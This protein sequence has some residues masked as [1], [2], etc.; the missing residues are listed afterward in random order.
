M[1]NA[2]YRTVMTDR[3][4]NPHLHSPQELGFRR[5]ALA[6]ARVVWSAALIFSAACSAAPGGTPGASDF[7]TDGGGGLGGGGDAAPNTGSGAGDVPTPDARSGEGGRAPD[8]GAGGQPPDPGPATPEKPAPGHW[9]QLPPGSYTEGAP[10][11]ESCNGTQNQ[12]LHAVTLSHP[13]ELSATE[14]TFAEYA[15]VFGAEHPAYAGCSSCPVSLVSFHGAAAVCNGYSKYAGL[16]PCYSCQTTAVGTECVEALSP[17]A[18]HGYRLPTE[19]EWEYANRAGT[20]TPIFNGDIVNC[21]GFDVGLDQIAWYLFNASGGAH[22]VAGKQGNA[23]GF[24]DMSGNVWEWTHDGYVSDRSTLPTLNPIGVSSE[25]LRV[26][27]GGSYNCTPEEVRA[28]H[29]SG[30][31]ASIAASNVGLRC[32]RTLD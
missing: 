1:A 19:A 30:L 21:S 4:L 22:P 28:A 24:Y 18:C 11:T 29:R 3:R 7:A 27:R 32:A 9:L 25:G 13:F 31:P 6:F 15:T 17:Y 16:T 26:M 8:A 20:S 14:V 2:G 5:T 23:W 12:V 10:K